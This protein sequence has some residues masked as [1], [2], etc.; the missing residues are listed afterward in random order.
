MSI[1]VQRVKLRYQLIYNN[2]RCFCFFK[3]EANIRCLCILTNN[4]NN[5]NCV[6]LN[7]LPVIGMSDR[8][9]DLTI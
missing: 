6:K 7:I 1:R 5:P 9:L 8:Y 3:C 2:H 4:Q